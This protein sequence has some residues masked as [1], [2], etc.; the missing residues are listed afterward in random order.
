MGNKIWKEYLLLNQ[1]PNWR[2]GFLIQPTVSMNRFVE[3]F[4][5][6]WNKIEANFSSR[7]LSLTNFSAAKLRAWIVY[8]VIVTKNKFKHHKSYAAF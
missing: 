8:V 1:F 4:C 2:W 6:N 3:V 5:V 7:F